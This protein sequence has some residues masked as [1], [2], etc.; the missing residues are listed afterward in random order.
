MQTLPNL[1]LK[2]PSKKPEI[3]LV[4]DDLFLQDSLQAVLS[5]AGYTARTYTAA[6]QMLEYLQTAQTDCCQCILMDV[7]LNGVD[8]IQ[9][10]K[11]LRSS[12]S[13]VPV[14]FMSGCPDAIKVNEA[15]RDGAHCF[16]FKPFN[17]AELLKALEDA[18]ASCSTDHMTGRA[19]DEAQLLKQL[20]L[21]TPKQLEVL[22][23]VANGQSNT[24]IAVKMNI[25]ARTVKMH[26]AGIMHRL[27]LAHVVD[28]VRFY[29]RSQHLLSKLDRPLQQPKPAVSDSPSGVSNSI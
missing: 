20:Q 9:A 22:P 15:W 2:I 12:Q 7:H 25:T 29:E 10:Q 24:N 21:L 13:R 14:V 1:P 6:E 16:L 27:G 18:I 19:T 4:E 11:I 8:G 28:L 23:W 26:R 17:S 5:L 3:L